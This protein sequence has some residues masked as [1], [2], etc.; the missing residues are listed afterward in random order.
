ML[1]LSVRTGQDNNNRY[2]KFSRNTILVNQFEAVDELE[3][4]QLNYVE[5]FQ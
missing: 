1:A 2:I 5:Y 3:K 4:F